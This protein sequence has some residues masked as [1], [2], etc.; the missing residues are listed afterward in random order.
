MPPNRTRYTWHC[1]PENQFHSWVGSLAYSRGNLHH[2]GNQPHSISLSDRR[3][4]YCPNPQ[5][6][7]SAILNCFHWVHL[8]ETRWL[9]RGTTRPRPHRLYRNTKRRSVDP[10]RPAHR[11]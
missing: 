1:T 5:A 3:S 11:G 8:A 9:A 7:G 2:P 4:E 6:K 10:P